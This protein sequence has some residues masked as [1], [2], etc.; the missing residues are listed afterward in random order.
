M[1][2]FLKL[3]YPIRNILFYIFEG[4]IIFLTILFSLVLLTFSNSYLFDFF[5]VLR[6]LVVTM[7]C[8]IALYYNDLYDFQVALTPYRIL[9]RLMQSLGI[10]SIVLA[11]IYFCFPMVVIDERAFALS[12]FLLA[13]FIVVWR[14][15]YIRLLNKGRFNE[16]ILLIGSSGLA[17]EIVEQVNSHL[18][19]GYTI[20][21]II[22]EDSSN[23]MVPIVAEKVSSSMGKSHFCDV[24]IQMGIKKVVVAMADRRSFFPAD[25]LL[26]CRVAGVDVLD[27]SSFYEMLTGKLPVIYLTPSW[28]IFSDGFA[29]SRFKALIKRV[30]DIFFALILLIGLSPMMLLTAIWIKL[31]SKGGI[32]FAQDRV[33]QHKK[34]YMVYKFRSM[35]ENAEAISGPVWA[36]SGDDRIT[37]VGK[38]IRKYRIDELPQLWNVLKGEMSLVGPRPERKHFTDQLEQKIPFY[39]KRFTVKP[40]ITGWAQVSFDYGASVEDAQEKLNYELFYI[41]NMSLLIDLVIL[42]KTIKTVFFGKGAR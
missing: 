38:I 4:I 16:S 36:K 30:S 13:V 41:K 8:Q 35:V 14:L 11:F 17:I 21:A 19:C 33:G 5:L 15:F 1:L 22:P 9:I 37:R 10:T 18:D 23:A 6:I 25:E 42:L 20:E 12:L 39:A 31:D 24:V 40:G 34:E 27:G 26:R 32:F 7:V 3:Y 29:K 2:S 28:L